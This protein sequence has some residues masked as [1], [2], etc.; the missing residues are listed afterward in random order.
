MVNQRGDDLLPGVQVYLVSLTSTG[1][2]PS[3]IR[4]LADANP[5]A[6][7][8]RMGWGEWTNSFG[9]IRA[10][11]SLSIGVSIGACGSYL[12]YVYP[13]LLFACAG[14]LLISTGALQASKAILAI[15]I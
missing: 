2:D 15:A 10:L 14:G 1:L 7:Q 5:Y 13:R 11:V 9:C 4:A 3:G 8:R 12:K 6:H